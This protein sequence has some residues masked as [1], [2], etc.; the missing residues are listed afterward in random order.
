V[1]VIA[2]LAIKLV[3][4]PMPLLI[5]ATTHRLKPTFGAQTN[6]PAPADNF[7][8]A[9]LKVKIAI[10]M[11]VILK[12]QVMVASTTLPSNARPLKLNIFGAPAI[13][14]AVLALLVNALMLIA[15]AI[16]RNQT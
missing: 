1:V 5:A 16:A 7:K 3:A 9:L 10:F 14:S 8:I 2:I 12:K 13:I 15:P 11:N 4:K 6:K